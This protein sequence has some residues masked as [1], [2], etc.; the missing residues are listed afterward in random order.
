[1]A[2]VGVKGLKTTAHNVDLSLENTIRSY[3]TN[4]ILGDLS[5][6]SNPKQHLAVQARHFRSSRRRHTAYR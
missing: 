6:V 5:S 3:A 2:T 1:M 4:V